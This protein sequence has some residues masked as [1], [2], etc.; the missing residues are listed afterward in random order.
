MAFYNN[1]TYS[2]N[3]IVKV[4]QQT[5]YCPSEPTLCK[6]LRTFQSSPQPDC[7]RAFCAI[8]DTALNTAPPSALCNNALP[9]TT[10]GFLALPRVYRETVYNIRERKK[11]ILVFNLKENRFLLDE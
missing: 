9:T 8:V 3:T 4:Q 11:T 6:T 2:I 10:I 5:S 7:T 1:I